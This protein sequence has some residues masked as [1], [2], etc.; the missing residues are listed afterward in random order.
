MRRAC[1]PLFHGTFL[2]SESILGFRSCVLPEIRKDLL[3]RG[4]RHF[5]PLGVNRIKSLLSLV[6]TWRGYADKL[7]VANDDH[8]GHSLRNT[9]IAGSQRRAKRRRSEHPAAKQR[10]RRDIGRGV[11]LP[12]AQRPCLHFSYGLSPL[13]PL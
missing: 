3:A 11:M 4:L 7:P 2:L 6:R 5:L 10:R 9:V 13:R 8:P 12:S 1:Q